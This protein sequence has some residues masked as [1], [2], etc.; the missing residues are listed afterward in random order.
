MISEKEVVDALKFGKELPQLK[1]QFQLLIEEI[2]RLEYRRNSLRTALSALQNQTSA[3]EDSL[4][5]YESAVDDKIQSIAEAHKKFAQL[6][7]IKNNSKDYRKIERLAEEKANDILN[8]KKAILSSAV[9][10]VLQAIRN[11]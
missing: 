2:Q 3:A 4:R 11:D 10:A 5:L 1:D 6:E 7:N 9:I 8:N